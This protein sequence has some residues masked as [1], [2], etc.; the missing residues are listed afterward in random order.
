[1]LL[2]NAPG[3]D[4]GGLRIAHQPGQRGHFEQRRLALDRGVDREGDIEHAGCDPLQL[5]RRRRQAAGCEL[6]IDAALGHLLDV[7]RPPLEH[8]VHEVSGRDEDVE[9]ELGLGLSRNG[10]DGG[11]HQGGGN[12]FTQHV[13]L[14]PGCRGGLLI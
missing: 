9:K 11:G 6:D 5:L 12:E 3:G 7:L 4:R 1:M 13:S 14:S 8:F 2:V 10:G